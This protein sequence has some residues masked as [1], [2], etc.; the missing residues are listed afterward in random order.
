MQI[1]GQIIIDLLLLAIIAFNAAR[2]DGLE[3]KYKRMG[4]H[5]WHVD[6]HVI[7]IMDLLDE[8][9]RKDKEQGK[10]ADDTAA[11]DNGR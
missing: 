10:G 9:R 5:I 11:I 7:H 2:I 3:K 8:Q 4:E 1:N 6:G